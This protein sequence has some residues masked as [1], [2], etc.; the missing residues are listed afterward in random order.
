MN[1]YQ[2]THDSDRA[3][4]ERAVISSM[5]TDQRCIP[6]VAA[7]L[8]FEDFVPEVHQVLFD[9]AAD[10]AE[11]GMVFDPII[12]YDIVKDK[13]GG[14]AAKYIYD[15]VDMPVVVSNVME[16]A[17]IVKRHS[18]MR[19][20]LDSMERLSQEGEDPDQMAGDLMTL[21]RD[22]LQKH[23]ATARKS[24]TALMLEVFDDLRNNKNVGLGTGLNLL[25]G[26]TGGMDP[27]D[28][29]IAAARPS[30]GKT[31]LG[32][33]IAEYVASTGVGV[34][35]YSL[36]TSDKNIAKRYLA[37][38]SEATTSEIFKRKLSAGHWTSISSAMDRISKLPISII[39]DPY[40]T[41][42]KIRATSMTSQNLG[43]IVVDY[44]Q[45]MMPDKRSGR[46]DRREVVGENS[47]ALRR[48]SKELNVPVLALAQL[49][50][51]D[52]E[53]KRPTL[54]ELKES[55]DLEQDGEKIMLLWNMDEPV[56]GV[57]TVGNYIAKN[58][59]G[60]TGTLVYKFHGP[61]M[62]FIETNEKYVPPKRFE[63]RP[64]V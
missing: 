5:L 14:D 61:H 11:R 16:Y 13:L 58:K 57:T 32:L 22:Y 40:T 1:L 62:K 55:G 45:L 53:H 9:A 28:Y 38:V 35:F 19:F 25:D 50:R 30:V 10:K 29:I 7:V 31:A 17:A 6:Q 33:Q 64:E 48:V 8:S 51:T 49:R 15:L 56:E 60:G 20:M 23:R 52:D 43:L 12:A 47:R 3:M 41:I 44:I 54:S 37:R 39:D 34:D 2:I 27:A 24:M 21:S 63:R 26:I 36:E 46:L 4:A 59:N 18:G 42:S